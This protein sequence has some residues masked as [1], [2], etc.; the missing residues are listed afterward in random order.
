MTLTIQPYQ[1][2]KINDIVYNLVHQYQSVNDLRTIGVLQDLAAEEIHD[3][4][5]GND[6]A[7]TQLI[8]NIMDRRLRH[9][10]TET[11]VKTLQEFVVPFVAPDKKQ[12]QQTFRKTKKLTLPDLTVV[13]WRDYTFFAWNDIATRRKYI[14]YY[15]Q[16]QLLGL[17]GDV[18]SPVIRGYCSICQH[19][20]NVTMFLALNKRHGDGRY[21]KKGNYICV[22][23]LQC[24]R[25]LHERALFDKFVT[26]IKKQ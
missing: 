16:D 2:M 1:Y 21:T 15:E 8:S 10:A 20:E 22:D 25:N 17:V 23:S 11:M 4:V 13:D 12:I 19:E 26:T 9:R 3:T 24:N 6:P 14:L 5:P 18:S 7:I